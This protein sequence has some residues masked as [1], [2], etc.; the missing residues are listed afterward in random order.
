MFLAYSGHNNGSAYINVR[1]V[2]NNWLETLKEEIWGYPVDVP[3]FFARMDDPFHHQ[4]LIF[5]F[6]PD[7]NSRTYVCDEDVDDARIAFELGQD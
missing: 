4:P 1:E 7:I 5:G 2:V 3:F 6:C